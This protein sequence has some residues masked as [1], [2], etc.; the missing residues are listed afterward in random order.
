MNTSMKRCKVL[1]MNPKL[2]AMCKAALRRL[3]SQTSRGDVLKR[4]RVG[5]T[6]RCNGCQG[7]FGRKEVSVDHIS[8][9]ALNTVQQKEG[10]VLWVD[11]NAYMSAVFCDESNLQVLC[12]GCHKAK[13]AS[14][15]KVQPLA[16]LA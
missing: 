4:A 9:V 5:A 7:L 10:D 12:T 16:P 1:A 3:W 6:W 15:R 11:W 8:P 14:E 13:S 2:A